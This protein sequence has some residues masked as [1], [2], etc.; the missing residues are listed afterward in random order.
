[1]CNIQ[2]NALATALCAIAPA[3]IAAPVYHV[4]NLPSF[5]GTRNQGNS[6][7]DAG[8]VS[9]FSTR[10][11]DL[12]RR[13]T[14]WISNAPTDLGTLGGPN[15]SIAWPVKNLHGRFVGISQMSTPEPNG[16]AWSCAP[17]FQIDSTG[18]AC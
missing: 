14:A 6:I 4:D 12:H 13:A 18:Y 15:S 8:V 2:R 3:A 10:P 7:N 16:E 11:G 17:F 1:M 9:G 5:G